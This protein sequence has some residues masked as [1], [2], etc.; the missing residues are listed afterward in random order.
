MGWS[1]K[2]NPSPAVVVMGFADA[3]P[4]LQFLAGD[5]LRTPAFTRICRH[6]KP[7]AGSPTRHPAGCFCCFLQRITSQRHLVLRTMSWTVEPSAR[8]QPATGCS[9]GGEPQ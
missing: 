4:I 8:E 2:R 9:V 3:Q 6:A 1:E 5:C 7:E